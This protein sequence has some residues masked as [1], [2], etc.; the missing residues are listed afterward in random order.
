MKYQKK[1]TPLLIICMLMIMLT[2]V[3]AQ[4]VRESDGLQQGR[5]A[6]DALGRTVTIDHEI[7]RV[8][9]VGRA[10]VMPA[11]ALYLFPSALDM[12]VILAKTDQGLGDFFDLARFESVADHRL[13]QQVGAEEIL[14]HRPDLVLT[15]ANNYDSIV[16]LLKP[17]DIPLF[18]MDLETP[19][20]WKHEIVELGKLLGDTATPQRVVEEFERRE[21]VVDTRIATLSEHQR[22]RILMMQVATADGVTAFSVSPKDWFQTTLAHRSGGVPVWLDA[23]LDSNAWRKVSFEQIAAWE[24]EKII[25]ISYKGPAEPF[26]QTIRK[27]PQWQNLSAVEQNALASAPADVLNYFQSDVRWILALQWLAAHLHPELFPEFDM[28]KEIRSFYRDFYGITSEEILKEFID[29]YRISIG[30]N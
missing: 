5:S 18:V 17:F 21:T 12:E 30:R 22:P 8:M 28:E 6:V 23:S 24:P 27:S 10:A 1:G 13:A 29:R 15:K 20:S 26:L 3:T 14:A 11:D 9:V 19:E 16:K 7:Q 4:A 2:P 25:L